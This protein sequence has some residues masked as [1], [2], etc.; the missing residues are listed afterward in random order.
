MTVLKYCKK[1]FLDIDSDNKN[2]LEKSKLDFSASTQAFFSERRAQDIANIINKI[3]FKSR[4]LVMAGGA[5]LNLDTN[6]EILNAFPDM[7]HFIAPCCDDTGQSLGALGILIVKETGLRPEAN[8]PYLGIGSEKISYKQDTVS[9]VANI[10]SRDGI[11]ILHNSKAEIG[12]RALGNRSFIGRANSIAVK[13]KLSEEIKQRESYRP[14]AP[15][16]IEEKVND[17]FIGPH[18][19]PFMLYKYDVLKSKKGEIAGSIHCDGSARVQ[20]VTK[21]SN[22]FLYDLIKTYGDK[23]GTYV[24]LNTSL[25]LKGDPI[26]NTLEDSLKIYEKIIGPKVLVRDGNIE[27]VED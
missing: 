2:L 16:T 23:T 9:K 4:N 8:L 21:K 15:V 3:D 5:N 27:A 6:T 25:N 14:V 20:T 12:P 17:Y 7:H 24:L 10:L 1:K 19:S 18:S 22:A 11:V 13:K 26:A